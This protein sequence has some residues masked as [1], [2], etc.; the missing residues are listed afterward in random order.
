MRVL[1]VPVFNY[2]NNLNADS[3]Y[4]IS[5]DWSRAICEADEDVAVHRLLPKPG[6]EDPYK[7]FTYDYE[8]VHERVHDLF[9]EQYT[10]YTM[11]EAN[12]PFDFYRRFHPLLGEYP[13]DAVVCTSAAKTIHVKPILTAVTAGD[14]QSFFNFE[15]LLRGLGSNEVSQVREDEMIIQGAGEV[16][17]HNLFESPMCQKIAVKSARRYLSASM[18]RRL[19]DRADMVY[20]GYDADQAFVVPEE[21]KSDE[22]TVVVRGRLTASKNVERIT[23]LYNKFHAAGHDLKIVITTGDRRGDSRVEDDLKSNRGI[24]FM[25][26][27]TKAEAN[28]VMRK[29][30]AFVFWSSHELFAVSVWEMLAAGL[31][32]VF[33]KAEWFKGLLPDDYPYVFEREDQAYAMMLDIYEN[34]DE[35]KKELAWV[36]KWV[37]DNYSYRITAAA[38]ADI[39]RSNSLAQKPRD[40]LIDLIRDKCPERM[41]LDE[42]AETVVK[43]S[44][45]GK[46][47]LAKYSHPRRVQRSIGPVELVRAAREAGFQENLKS[48]TPVFSRVIDH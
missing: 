6:L 12:A 19:H 27:K 48:E 45:Q 7:R 17:A 32:G 34:Y 30:H 21:Q 46:V 4:L 37:K 3:I 11:E 29:A 28:K 14:W 22:F 10:W 1:L 43:H 2:P 15:L 13:V 47:V 25:N 41:T 8:P 40:W 35:R 39:I 20:S 5:S 24:E 26:L 33:K 31:I 44:E 9:V 36:A 23:S 42:L 18:I 38:A 16:M